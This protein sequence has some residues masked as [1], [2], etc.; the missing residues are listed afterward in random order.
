MCFYN[1][2]GIES[3]SH[4][5]TLRVAKKERKCAVDYCN[6]RILVGDVYNNHEGLDTEN[7]GYS[8]G[9]C[10]ECDYLRNEIVNQEMSSGCSWHEA[11]CPLEELQ[12]EVAERKIVRESY[13]W[14]QKRLRDLKP[15]RKKWTRRNGNHTTTSVRSN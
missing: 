5:E 12:S 15:P 8:Y 10:C 4:R 6:R 3:I 9:V 7:G 14:C 1:D 2:S 11:W 13:E